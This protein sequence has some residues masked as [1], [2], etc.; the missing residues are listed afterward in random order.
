AATSRVDLETWHRRLGHIS[1]DSVL[2]MVKSGM[3]KGMAIV[4]DKAPN[5]PCR[6]CLRGKQTRNPIP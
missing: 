2:K 3:A 1:V 6:S 4:G 5:S